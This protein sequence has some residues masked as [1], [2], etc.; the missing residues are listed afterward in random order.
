MVVSV[1]VAQSSVDL[2]KFKGCLVPSVRAVSWDPRRDR[3][4][5]GTSGSD[6]YEINVATGKD[7]N[8]GPHIQA[9]FQSELWG[10]DTHP[11]QVHY[12]L[13]PE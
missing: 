10:A 5:V 7:A 8:N 9:H 6:I 4:V 2:V 11:S 1:L 12:V 3:I 13:E